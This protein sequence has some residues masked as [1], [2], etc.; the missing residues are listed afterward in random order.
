MIEDSTPPS[1]PLERD[2]LYMK[3]S[4]GSGRATQ[5]VPSYDQFRLGHGDPL[6]KATLRHDLEIASPKTKRKMIQTLRD[7]GEIHL[8]QSLPSLEDMEMKDDDEEEPELRMS[9]GHLMRLGINDIVHLPNGE[10]VSVPILPVS[11]LENPKRDQLQEH[12]SPLSGLG[13]SDIIHLPNNK[14]VSIPC[15]PIIPST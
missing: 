12:G 1:P 11:W 2:R 5:F 10:V 3:L 4:K 14:V 15:L 6:L 8:I 13:M 9:P 7:K